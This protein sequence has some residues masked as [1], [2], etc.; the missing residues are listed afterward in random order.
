MKSVGRSQGLN[1]I[2]NM[3]KSKGN[4]EKN[5][6]IG[7][8]T[9]LLSVKVENDHKKFFFATIVGLIQ[10]KSPEKLSDELKNYVK[11]V[12]DLEPEKEGGRV[13]VFDDIE[14]ICTHRNKI[15]GFIQSSEV[16]T[17]TFRP[18]RKL[19]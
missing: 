4:E 11:D 14:T 6:L 2:Q 10:S 16:E 13:T 12:L 5:I 15:L 3:F 8:L 18:W 1:S 17:M 19:S 7:K 9:K